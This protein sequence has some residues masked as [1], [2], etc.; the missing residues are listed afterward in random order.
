MDTR[1]TGFDLAVATA[2]VGV[3]TLWGGDVNNPSGMGRFI[4]DCYFSGKDLPPC[5]QHPIA[6]K[7]RDGSDGVL[8]DKATNDEVMTFLREV[9]F[10]EAVAAMEAE[11]K[12]GRLHPLRSSYLDNLARSLKV[13]V[14]MALAHRGLVGPVPFEVSVVASTG[15]EP[16]LYDVTDMRLQVQ[17]LLE[18]VGEGVNKHEGS[19]WQ[20]VQAW[21][22]AK[23]IQKTELYQN[24]GI[25]A[26]S[27][28]IIKRLDYLTGPKMHRFLPPDMLHVP[29]TN[30]R[31]LP[32][33]GAWFSGSLNYLGKARTPDG[34]PEF[35]ATYE[36]NAALE[37]SEPEFWHL[38]SH[39]VVPG[40]IMNF[41][42]L[43]YLYHTGAEGYGFESTIQTMNSRGSTLAEGI[44]NNAL[45]FAWGVDSV[46][47]IDVPEL[48]LGTLVSQLQ[49]FA[50]ANI[51]YRL[52]ALGMK[53][54]EVESLT[55][56]ECLLSNERAKKLT[57]S[58]GK[59]PL[60]GR[61][62]LPSYAVG[63]KTVADL[64]QQHGWE[65][66][67]PAIYGVH[68]PVDVVTVQELFK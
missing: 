54:E 20:A 51:A 19:L 52:H 26:L 59:H 55:R 23:L 27:A 2:I 15:E 8:G 40:H 7:L 3:D 68:G 49:D 48:Q 5:Y 41:A 34:D 22:Q 57:H 47:D 46:Y 67:A 12:D 38:I 36:I 43:H 56:D 6:V 29:R 64:V 65:K 35:E 42:L 32:I 53:P 1:L 60:L 33:E 9:E 50:K 63:T 66:V 21:R 25:A 58:W 31:F 39:E 37:I 62:Y 4:A 61:M 17:K 44:A 24:G 13:M 30:V 28:D 18:Q 45:L 11:V 16:K 14:N 10:Y